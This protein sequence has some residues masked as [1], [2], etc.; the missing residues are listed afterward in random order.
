MKFRL[1]LLV[2]LLILVV[3][4]CVLQGRYGHRR[5]SASPEQQQDKR[6]EPNNHPH[7]SDPSTAGGRNPQR[8]ATSMVELMP[9][10]KQARLKPFTGTARDTVPSGHTMVVG[11]WAIEPGKRVLALLTPVVN[12][13]GS[14]SINGSYVQVPEDVLGEPGWEQFQAV[15]SDSNVNGTYP[16]E[17]AGKFNEMLSG[18]EGARPLST[19]KV[20]T[21]SG[22]QATIEIV[23]GEDFGMAVTLLPVVS[24]DKQSV[25]LSV[26]HALHR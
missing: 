18:M 15:A 19:P 13:D 4:T 3:L 8:P 7:S 14:V 22:H 9:Q 12:G 23:G 25:D 10:L 6:T 11:G 2:F 20:I 24:A 1:A 21:L 16:P 5:T 26:T 17:Q